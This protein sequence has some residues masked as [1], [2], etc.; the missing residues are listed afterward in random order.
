MEMV[1]LLPLESDEDAEFVQKLLQEF[2]EETGS[3]VAKGLLGNWEASKKKFVKVFPYEYQRA[4]KDLEAEKAKE[5]ASNGKAEEEANKVE[6]K[7]DIE[8]IESVVKDTTMAEIKVNALQEQLDKK[9]GFVKYKREARSYRPAEKRMKDWEEIYDFKHVRKGL[10]KQAA[11][12]MDCGV[13]F[14]HSTTHGC[15][16]G[17]I[18]PKFNDLVFQN[19]WKEALHALLQVIK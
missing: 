4:L 12:C 14:C 6:D 19:D 18:I 11:R 7:K 3:E 17:N 15:P 8:D 16:L 10:R 1:E 9:R 5:E 2:V 13:P